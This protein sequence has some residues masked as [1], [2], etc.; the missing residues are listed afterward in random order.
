[1]QKQK[2]KLVTSLVRLGCI[3]ILHTGSSQHSTQRVSLRYH[4][5]LPHIIGA[6]W[7]TYLKTHQMA[8][9]PSAP[10][11]T[12][13]RSSRLNETPVTWPEW[14]TT[15]ANKCPVWK[16][17][18]RTFPVL[19]P[20]TSI[21]PS[22]DR[23]RQRPSSTSPS[24][25]S[26]CKGDVL[27]NSQKLIFFSWPI[28]MICVSS[29][30][31]AMELIPPM[32]WRKHCRRRSSFKFQSIILLSLLEVN[33]CESSAKISISVIL[34]V[35]SF[36]WEINSRDRN[37]Q[38]RTSPSSPPESRNLI[39]WLSFR[40]EIPSAWALSMYQR[41]APESMSWARILRRTHEGTS[42]KRC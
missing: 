36:M 13:C 37:S 10:V 40:A 17:H 33:A 34:W 22:C 38:S 35:C 2:Q 12:T 29:K 28:E 27:F 42:N 9:A 4:R 41:C 25:N 15:E 32:R 30:D 23:T 19:P 7:I 11:D 5:F 14:A 31:R 26:A 20:D 8:M 24:T 16:L 21:S 6:C 18:K 39:L 1:M 3:Y